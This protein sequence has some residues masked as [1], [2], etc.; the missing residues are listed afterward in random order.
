MPDTLNVIG[1]HGWR[2]YERDEGLEQIARSIGR[3]EPQVDHQNIRVR[4]GWGHQLAHVMVN[5]DVNGEP[6]ISINKEEKYK[7]KDLYRQLRG[8]VDI[9]TPEDFRRFMQVMQEAGERAGFVE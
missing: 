9:H 3:P 1:E 6:Y 8:G 2:V 5:S 7:T 4:A